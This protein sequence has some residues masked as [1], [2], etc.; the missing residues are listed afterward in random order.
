MQGDPMSPTL[1]NIYTADVNH[2]GEEGPKAELILYTD[3]MVIRAAEEDEDVQRA[4]QLET[5]AEENNLQ[6]NE[7]KTVQMTFRKGG[8][9]TPKDNITLHK[10][11]LQKL[12]PISC[13][14]VT[15]SPQLSQNTLQHEHHNHISLQRHF[16]H[17]C[18]TPP[19]A[20][21]LQ[22]HHLFF[23]VSPSTEFNT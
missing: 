9:S 12:S 22:Y 4:I 17:S 2:I 7:E 20:V 15:S 14:R 5:W 23:C 3:N 13:P 16:L 18:L 21:S 19:V 11:P 10:K 8:K 6:I 1:F